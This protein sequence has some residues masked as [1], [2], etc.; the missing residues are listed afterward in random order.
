MGKV[1]NYQTESV[2]SNDKILA[3]DAD[4]GETK[5][6]LAGDIANGSLDVIYRGF[7]TQ[8]GTSA[9]TQ[10]VLPNNTNVFTYSYTSPGVFGITSD[11]NWDSNKKFVAIIGNPSDYTTVIE[12][13]KS[14]ANTATLKTF[15]SGTPANSILTD[16]YIE[17][18]EVTV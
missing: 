17:I 12:I 6:V 9:P 8:S 3:S 18:R 15:T 11:I 13:K 10:E 4:T 16:Q 14:G 2:K 5:N 7:V 1:N